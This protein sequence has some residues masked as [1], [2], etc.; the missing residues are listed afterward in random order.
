MRPEIK[1]ID[2]VVATQFDSGN[3][4]ANNV[5]TLCSCTN[6]TGVNQRIGN[7]IS[8]KSLEIVGAVYGGT[9]Q[10]NQPQ[11]CRILVV[12]DKQPDPAAIPTA[13]APSLLNSATP[14]GLINI[15]NTDRYTIIYDKLFTIGS[16]AGAQGFNAARAFHIKC[17][18]KNIETRFQIGAVFPTSNNLCLYTMSET[19]PAP[20]ANPT[21]VGFCS[22]R[23]RFTDV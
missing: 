20:N 17:D 9:L 7:S 15:T 8:L 14:A 12:W 3:S 13:P 19:I 10:T 22:A 11:A 23:V 16:T 2:T 18:L 21:W 5:I 4:A 6:G 1:V